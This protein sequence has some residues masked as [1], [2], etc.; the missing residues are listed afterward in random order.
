MAVRAQLGRARVRMHGFHFAFDGLAIDV[1]DPAAR[2]LQV[3]HVAFFQVDDL[4]RRAGQRHGVGRDKVF[5]IA[6]ADDQGRT[7]ARGDHAMRLVAAEHGDRIRAVQA[8]DGLLHG[9]EQVAVI[10]VLDQMGDPFR[11][12]L[13]LRP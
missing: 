11:V 1:D 6:Q 12:R 4:V 3:D 7:L 8:F 10:H 5:T 13:W 2:Q 9:L